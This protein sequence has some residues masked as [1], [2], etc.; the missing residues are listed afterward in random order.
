MFTRRDFTTALLSTGMLTSSKLPAFAQIGDQVPLEIGNAD[1]GQA[2]ELVEGDPTILVAA[3][4]DLPNGYAESFGNRVFKSLHELNAFFEERTGAHFIEFFNTKVAGK[5]YWAGKKIQGTNV[6]QNFDVYWRSCIADA[7]LSLMQFIAYMAVFI[8]EINGN[9][10]SKTETFGSADHPGISYLFD[11]VTITS[12]GGRK[13]RKKSYNTR[14]GNYTVHQQLNEALFLKERQGLKF[15]AELSNTTDQVWNGTSYP[16]NHFPTSGN[17]EESGIILEADFFKFRGRGLIQTTWR[18]NYLG[19][20]KFILTN[21]NAS[22]VIRTYA[23]RWQGLTPDLACTVSSSSDWDALF[24]DPDA[25]LLKQAVKAH[26]ASGKYLPLSKDSNTL[27][28]TDRGSLIAMGNGI[29][30]GGY[31][32]NLKSRVR[33]ICIAIG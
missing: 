15:A 8:N 23:A 27:N 9:L 7:P 18:A 14:P 31:G 21:P 6:T 28:G 4:D 26:A 24:S 29:G 33:Q 25:V 17:L 2:W 5:A 10:R 11:V 16:K 19:L 22:N 1:F 3:G 13:W 20:A 32:G 12:P 30:G